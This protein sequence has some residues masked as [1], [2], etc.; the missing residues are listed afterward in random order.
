MLI[1]DLD[2]PDLGRSREIFY[3]HRETMTQ[4]N[5]PIVYTIA[6]PL[7][8]QPEIR[9]LLGIPIFLPNVKLHERGQTDLLSDGYHT[10]RMFVRKRMEPTLI[11]DDALD[12]AIRTIGGIFRELCR[13]M[14]SAIGYAKQARRPQPRIEPDDVRKAE[15]EIRAYYWRFL[16]QDDRR[17][18]RG[19][20]RYNQYNMPDQVAPLLQSLAAVEYADGEPWCDVH[21]VLYSLLDEESS[22]GNTGNQRS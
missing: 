6:S 7:F 2:K 9:D 19:I 5:V 15:A 20:R 17:I 13:V 3:D 21:P 1:D 16:S 22:N 11:T 12:A 18:L 10:L 14:R 4:P 8:Y